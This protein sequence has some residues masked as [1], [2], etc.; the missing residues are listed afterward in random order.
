MDTNEKSESPGN[1]DNL[2]HM[3]PGFIVQPSQVQGKIVALR[4]WQFG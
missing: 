4:L 3:Q 2:P 1:F